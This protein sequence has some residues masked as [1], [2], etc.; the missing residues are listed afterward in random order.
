MTSQQELNHQYHQIQELNHQYHQVL[1]VMQELN[2]QYHHMLRVIHHMLRVMLLQQYQDQTN[3]E[4]PFLSTLWQAI[5]HRST[6][7]ALVASTTTRSFVR[8]AGG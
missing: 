8:E 2:H 7:W 5:T 6:L 1:R 4:I 3:Q